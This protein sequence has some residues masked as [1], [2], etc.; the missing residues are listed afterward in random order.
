MEV[1]EE[2]LTKTE[3]ILNFN[4]NKHRQNK[5]MFWT[6]QR[7][8]IIADFTAVF[9]RNLLFVNLIFFCIEIGGRKPVVRR[10]LSKHKNLPF[11][12][13]INLTKGTFSVQVIYVSTLMYR[14]L[15]IIFEWDFNISVHGT[16]KL[17]VL[18]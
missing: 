3:E 7:S 15:C 4:Y 8:L 13:T 12:F 5:H 1:R 2:K 6:N 9:Y 16:R 14:R 11:R 17:V 18:T 10:L